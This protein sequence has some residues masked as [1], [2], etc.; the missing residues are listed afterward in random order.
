MSDGQI[1]PTTLVDSDFVQAIRYA[2]DGSSKD[3]LARV[4]DVKETVLVDIPADEIVED[5]THRFVT[6]AE[7]A[8][9]NTTSSGGELI[10]YLAATSIT[11]FKVVT[12]TG[13]IADSDAVLQRNKIIGISTTNVLSGFTG[14]AKG[15]GSIINP[16]WMWSIGDK[17]YLNGT[18]LS[19][20]A[21]STGYSQLI[22]TATAS[23]TIDVKLGEPILF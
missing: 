19:T 11:A 1:T 3:F 15:F 16:A 6:D 13:Q 4:L 18:S 2:S 10:S 7:I 22:G 17:I 5:S 12:S 21:P 20:T 14:K 8:T 9:W 23:D